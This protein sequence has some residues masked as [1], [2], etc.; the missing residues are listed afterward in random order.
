MKQ[1][2]N[3]NFTCTKGEPS[4]QQNGKTPVCHQQSH[5]QSDTVILAAGDYPQ[6]PIPLQVLQAAKTV[7][8]CDG[9]TQAYVAHG[10]QP[11]AIVGDG[12]SLSDDLRQRFTQVFHQEHEQATNDLSKAVRYLFSLGIHRF[13]IIGATGKR[14]DHTLGNISLLIEYMRQGAAVSMFTD[15][16]LFIPCHDSCTLAVSPGQ[17]VSIINF[18]ATGFQSHGLQ[19]PLYDFTNW[20]QGTL[21]AAIASTITITAQG[22][23]LLYLPYQA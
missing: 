7:V 16:G 12:D 5:F 8:C 15:Y 17:Q 11:T 2:A 13:V 22:D 14:E 20:W 9:A 3:H 10:G 4:V 1:E 18:G 19:Y 6:H 21:N 23:F